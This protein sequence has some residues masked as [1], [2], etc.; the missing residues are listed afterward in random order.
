MA[1]MNS[2]TFPAVLAG[3]AVLN[4]RCDIAS[5]IADIV[6]QHRISS[7][8]GC[9]DINRISFAYCFLAAHVDD[10]WPHFLSAGNEV[11]ASFNRSSC[12]T[13][14]FSQSNADIQRHLQ[15]WPALIDLFA[16]MY[17]FSQT[18]ADGLRHLQCLQCWAGQLY[19]I[20]L[21]HC[22]FFTI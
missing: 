5:A 7:A 8:A 16:A 19:S 18:D 1:M 10:E 12:I 17:F 6:P 13:V 15:C 14:F 22:V 3:L 20:F 4:S 11:L 9:G 2:R 21:H